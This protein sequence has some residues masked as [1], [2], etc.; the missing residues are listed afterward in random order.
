MILS[1]NLQNTGIHRGISKKSY[2]LGWQICDLYKLLEPI[3]F[4]G[5]SSEDFQIYTINKETL[6]NRLRVFVLVI[7]FTPTV[8]L[9]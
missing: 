8:Q 7:H 4:M 3:L 2:Q 5:C 6:S 9:Q 1:T